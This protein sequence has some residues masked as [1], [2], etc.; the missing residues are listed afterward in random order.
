M[1]VYNWIHFVT[2]NEFY[3]ILSSKCMEEDIIFNITLTSNLFYLK[4]L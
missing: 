3:T 1:Y 2:A 4:L